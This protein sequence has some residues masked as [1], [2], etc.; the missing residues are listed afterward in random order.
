MRLNES[1]WFVWDIN[2]SGILLGVFWVAEFIIIFAVPF[3]GAFMYDGV[4]LYSHN[5]W[6]D[7]RHLPYT[8]SRFDEEDKERIA[9]GDLDII[10]NQP[11]ATSSDFSTVSVCYLDNEP[12]EY[13]V[14]YKS[15]L[16]NNG[17][18]NHNSPS[19]AIELTREKIEHLELQLSTKY[20]DMDTSEPGDDGLDLE[21]D[22][23]G[24]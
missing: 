17:N 8:F 19:R 3:I 2:F 4:F 15:S 16:A 20:A 10:I 24:D 18:I 21:E 22:Y 11:M 6:A 9:A 7:P 14:L 13:I 5:R 12:T 1:G 23:Y